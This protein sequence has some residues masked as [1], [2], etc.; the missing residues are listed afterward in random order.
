MNHEWPQLEQ[1]RRR[2]ADFDFV[3]VESLDR[4]GNEL[5]VVA[6][7]ATD[8]GECRISLDPIRIQVIRVA[9]SL[10]T[11]HFEEFVPQS[12]TPDEVL[13]F[14]FASDESLRKFLDFLGVDWEDLLP[15]TPYQKSVLLSMLRE[16]LEWAALL[17]L[18]SRRTPMLLVRDGL[19][20]SVVINETVFDAL[21]N[22]LK[23]LTTK[24]GHLLAGVA[25]RS[26]VVNYLSLAFAIEDAFPQEHASYTRV[27]PELEREAAPGQYRWMSSRA[28]G[29]LF[30]ARLDRGAGVPLF[31][32]DVANWHTEFVAGVMSLLHRSARGAF[33][34]RGYPM[35]LL[36]AHQ[37]ARLAGIDAEVLQ[38]I[39]LEEV[40]QRDDRTAHLAREQMLLGQEL[41][42]EEWK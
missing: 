39:V 34:L 20:R 32:V 38:S 8:G 3:P 21:R 4:H 24:N 26:S 27:P 17:R 16:L 35:E 14:F 9:D 41:L 30:V 18:A 7:V 28:L 31:P 42:T 22:R 37:N 23:E 25:K 11:V 6:M 29:D 10:G 12:L 40:L 5:P 19:L 33:P 1:V 15:N 13:R 2:V 36:D